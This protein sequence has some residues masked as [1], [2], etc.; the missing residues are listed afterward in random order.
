MQDRIRRAGHGAVGHPA[1]CRHRLDRRG[2]RHQDWAAVDRRRG[3]GRTPVGGVIDR[4]TRRR[5]RDGDRLR[6]AVRPAGRAE[7]RRG[8]LL[9]ADRAYQHRNGVPII[10]GHRQIQHAIEIEVPLDHERGTRACLEAQRRLEGPIAVAQQHRD[11]GSSL[12]AGAVVG[13]DEI[14]FPVRIEIARD[15]GIRTAPC[16]KEPCGLEGPIAVAQQHRDGVGDDRAGSIVETPIRGN[17]KIRFAIA[18]EVAH[19][20]V[21]WI[22]VPHLEG[23]WRLEGSVPPAKQ[24]RDQG[25]TSVGDCQVQLAIG[26]EVA[27][28]HNL[29]VRGHRDAL[30]RTERPIPVAQQHREGVGII[31]G[32]RQIRFAVPI[33]VTHCRECG[34]R[35]RVEVPGRLE[36]SIAVA[37]QHGHRGGKKIA[38]HQVQFAIPIDVLRG[39]GCRPT[40]YRIGRLDAEGPVAVA[41]QHRDGVGEI[42]DHCQVQPAAAREIARGHGPRPDAN[43]VDPRRS[44]RYRPGQRGIRKQERKKQHKSDTQHSPP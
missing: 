33:E 32:R 31:V 1:G 9:Q 17:R 13:D 39:D 34:V 15:H 23:Q 36:G 19:G 5:V 40:A 4:G 7:R 24:D 18:V 41:C 44:E 8:H 6:A 27:Y 2:L 35:A 43:P 11:G 29:G 22:E 10:V 16:V 20:D 12:R 25:R 21:C 14:H 42:V 3:R 37:Q 38:H 28:G 26:I 30:C